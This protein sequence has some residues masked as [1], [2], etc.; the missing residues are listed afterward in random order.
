MR[1]NYD[2][3][4]ITYTRRNREY[5]E[6]L[7]TICQDTSHFI[8]EFLRREL[9][10]T[11]VHVINSPFDIFPISCDRL[12]LLPIISI[13]KKEVWRYSP[14]WAMFYTVF[15]KTPNHIQKTDKSRFKLLFNDISSENRL[16]NIV[17]HELAHIATRDLRL[18]I[19]LS[20]GVSILTA[21]KYINI[22]TVKIDTLN[23]INLT[24]TLNEFDTIFTSKSLKRDITIYSKG[25]WATRFLF[26]NNPNLFYG[27]LKKQNSER[28]ITKE[29]SAIYQIK[30]DD[31]WRSFG[32]IIYKYYSSNLLTKK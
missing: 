4:E 28:K 5:A 18:P 29:I 1:K 11:R 25:Y 12:L 10:Y 22:Q 16:A 9:A 8:K 17:C 24:D 20:E 3:L 31:F 32:R 19:W 7:G 23:Y 2:K 21:E 13:L 14:A 26:E 27:L 30:G 15:I 6:T